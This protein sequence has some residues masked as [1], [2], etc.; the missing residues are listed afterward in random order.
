MTPQID[1]KPKG[2]LRLFGLPDYLKTQEAY[3][4]VR[5]ALIEKFACTKG[6]SDLESSAKCINCARLM[7][8]RR[9]FIKGLGFKSYAQFYEW[10]KVH[11]LI[12][13]YQ[14]N[15]EKFA[16]YKMENYMAEEKPKA[17]DKSGTD[18]PSQ[19]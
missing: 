9:A 10:R 19:Q 11:E 1:Y 17:D 3:H 18:Q 5:R 2:N 6:H 13:A 4:Y 14:T 7:N 12:I 8:D 16:K 15:P